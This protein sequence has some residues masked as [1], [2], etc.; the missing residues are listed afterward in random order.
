M[1]VVMYVKITV[2][3]EESLNSISQDYHIS[4]DLTDVGQICDE[5]KIVINIFYT[6]F[7]Q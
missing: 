7:L 4:M 5:L 6:L 2:L 1:A 3:V